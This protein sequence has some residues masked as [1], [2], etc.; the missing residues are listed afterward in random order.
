VSPRSGGAWTPSAK[1]DLVKEWDDVARR[2]PDYLADREREE[3]ARFVGI[4]SDGL[5]W[6]V[7]ELAGGDLAKL[8]ET[9]L[10]PEK[11]D[12]FLAWLDGAVALK[13]ELPPDPL[14]IRLELGQDSVAYRRASTALQGLWAR[15]KDEPAV[16]LKRQLWAQLLKLVYGKDVESDA[17]WFQHTFL[18]VVAKAIAV[19]VLDLREDDPRQL[20]SG[21]AFE[22][23]G[24]GG[25]V[26]SD[27][28]DWVVADR[29]GEDLVRRIMARWRSHASTQPFRFTGT[30]PPPR[31][32]PKKLPRRRRCP[33]ACGSSAPASSSGTLSPKP[34]SPLASMR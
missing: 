1:S 27:F 8:K 10:D 21:R 19:A 33:K 23:A 13:K 2:M 29:D 28:F 34:E 31:P 15:L 5:R 12:L 22:A 30:S 24:I 17:L 11:P 25:A 9:Q 16:A 7:F 3:G 18:V 4:A 26:E 32:K 20:L 14:T 6:A